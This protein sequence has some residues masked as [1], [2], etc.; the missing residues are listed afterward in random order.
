MGLPPDV[1]AL[2]DHN[3]RFSGISQNTYNAVKPY[4]VQYQVPDEIWETVALMES[5]G[6]P[7]AKNKSGAYGLFQLL[8]PGGQGDAAIKAGLTPDQLF[9][10]GINAKYAMPMIAKAY[11]A[12]R[13]IFDG[14]NEWWINFASTS[15]HPFEN[16][17]VT[18]YVSTVGHRL[19]AIWQSESSKGPSLTN[20]VQ[21]IV[22]GVQNT[23]D[24]TKTIADFITMLMNGGLVKIG[25][26]TLALLIIIVGFV[27]VTKQ[28]VGMM[29]MLGKTL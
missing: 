1:Q 8:T 20:P 4:A 2:L 22:S 27:V 5:G 3:I 28:D 13:D 17:T 29:S 25:L 6:N 23:V 11:V 10:P 9:D 15:G 19:A 16:G 12:H 14:S 7:Q 26:F 24:A 18:D 21:P